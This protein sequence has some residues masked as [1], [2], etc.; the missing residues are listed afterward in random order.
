MTADLSFSKVMRMILET[1]VFETVF[2]KGLVNWSKWQA[3]PWWEFSIYRK[4]RWDRS[5]WKLE[6]GIN[7]IWQI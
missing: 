4:R 3:N 2:G 7:T 6:T 1:G 5:L